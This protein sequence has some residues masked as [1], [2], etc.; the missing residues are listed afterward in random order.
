MLTSV[1]HGTTN[2]KN[3]GPA[4]ATQASIRNS[5]GAQSMHLA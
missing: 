3:T 4:V 2:K 1:M 5:K